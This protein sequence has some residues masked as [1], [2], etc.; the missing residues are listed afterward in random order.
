MIIDAIELI[1]SLLRMITSFAVLVGNI[2][3]TFLPAQIKYLQPG[4]HHYDYYL[5]NAI[6]RVTTFMDVTMFSL[7][8]YRGS[9]KPAVASVLSAR[10]LPLL[11]LVRSP[12]DDC[13]H[14]DGVADL[15]IFSLSYDQLSNVQIGVAFL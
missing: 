7:N 10:L 3:K 6:F 14:D 2:R 12:R 4:Q 1:L 5:L 15:L 11:V 8:F 9:T 13:R